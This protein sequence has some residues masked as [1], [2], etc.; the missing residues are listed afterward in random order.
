MLCVSYTSIKLK[1]TQMVIAKLMAEH[2]S[3]VEETSVFIYQHVALR[4]TNQPK[5]KES[6]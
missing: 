5:S 6:H 4:Y 2:K 3:E 1:N